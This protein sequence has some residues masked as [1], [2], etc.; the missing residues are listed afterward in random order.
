MTGERDEGIRWVSFA[1]LESLLTKIF[2]RVGVSDENA[3]I[4]GINCAMCERDGTLSHSIFPHSRLSRH[5][6]KRL[7]GWK[8]K[9]ACRR[10]RGPLSSVLM[11]A[12]ASPNRPSPPQPIA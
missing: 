2:V 12:T 1:E 7:G 8:D 4:L 5:A 3:R 6:E 11:P 10:C 9:T